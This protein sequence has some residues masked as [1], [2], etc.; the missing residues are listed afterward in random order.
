M[1]SSAGKC[2]ALMVPAIL[3]RIG[4]VEYQKCCLALVVILVFALFEVLAPRIRVVF[5]KTV[6][7]SVRCKAHIGSTGRTS[8]TRGAL[9]NR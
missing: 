1:L 6:T 4:R 8:S 3:C 9:G 5:K 7:H 2:V